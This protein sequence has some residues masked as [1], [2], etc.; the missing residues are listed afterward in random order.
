MPTTWGLGYAIGGLGSP[1]SPKDA[2]TTFGIG[3]VGGGFACGDTATGIAVAVTKNM[4]TP[5]FT[6]SARLID[7][8]TAALAPVG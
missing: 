8:V 4:L 2:S 6:A 5:D 7:M 1:S 3:G